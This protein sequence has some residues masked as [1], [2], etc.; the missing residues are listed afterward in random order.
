MRFTGIEGR[1]EEVLF[2][3]SS[4]NSY[5]LIQNAIETDTSRLAEIPEANKYF[6]KSKG[7]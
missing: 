6:G 7:G 3:T 5:E 1:I 4:K 2:N